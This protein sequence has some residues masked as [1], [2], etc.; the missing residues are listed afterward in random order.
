MSE[1]DIL[2]AGETLIDFLPNRPGSLREVETFT[3]RPGGAPANVAVGLATLAE[4]PWFW[5]RVGD[6]PFGDDLVETLV[7]HGLPDEFVERDPE[8]KT[9]LAFVSH[10]EH[11]DREFSFYRDGTADTRMEPGTIDDALLERVSWVHL[12]GVTLASEPSRA[13]TLDLAAR[14]S[15]RDCTV[16]FDPNARPELWDDRAEFERLVGEALGHVD[17]LKATPDDLAEAGIDGDGA[18]LARAACKRGPHTT[19]LTLGG[20]GA[21][22]VATEEAP[23]EGKATH[24][25]YR[26]E[27]VDTT[28]AGDA[29]TA[30]A[31][32]ALAGGDGLAEA[33]AFAN[34]VAA[35]TTTAEGA[36]TALPDRE[37]VERVRG[38][39]PDDE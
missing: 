26:V 25:G 27:P 28:G 19:L 4:T 34:A 18:D 16:S 8:T 22:A 5:T 32:A 36:M 38:G 1:P 17:V 6:D 31:I 11:A 13:A 2:V 39:T 37:R 35:T 15:E 3:R 12:G 29:F 7:G 20:E 30:G 24:S 23:W 33:L 21:L 14:A 10:D 9:T